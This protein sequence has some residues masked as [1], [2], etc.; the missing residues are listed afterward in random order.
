MKNKY[1]IPFRLYPG[2]HI[3]QYIHT[4]IQYE[5]LFNMMST[6]RD[7]YAPAPIADAFLVY[8]PPKVGIRTKP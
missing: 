1:N 3:Q 6:Y 7:G 2:Q 4:L 5:P 8:R